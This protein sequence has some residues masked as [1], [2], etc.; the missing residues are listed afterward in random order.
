MITDGLTPLGVLLLLGLVGGAL[1]LGVG[2]VAALLMDR[3]VWVKRFVLT[4]LSGVA[5]YLLL[6]FGLSLTSR[7]R[8]LARNQGKHIC[9]LDCHSEYSVVGVRTDKHLGSR[10]AAG[11]FYIVTVRVLF[12]SA[13]IGPRRGMAPL[14]IG[15]RT[16]YVLDA[17]GREYPLEPDGAS[18]SLRH[19]VV[20]GQSY[21]TD[22]VF[23]LPA[24]ISKP[25][26]FV[27]ATA[28]APDRILIGSEN[29][30]LH[31]K[32]LFALS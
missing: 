18:D 28:A 15:P 32:T 23:D 31:K 5:L 1:A 4:G 13:T 27:G 19:P 17:G 20:P 16:A 2:I 3:G 22:L 6:L 9:E 24:T 11:T 29:S 30:V 25:L 8:I 7:T 14:E 26:L 12:D 21:T 10:T